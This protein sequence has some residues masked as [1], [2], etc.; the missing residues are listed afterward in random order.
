MSTEVWSTGP[1][2]SVAALAPA[3]GFLEGCVYSVGG[4]EGGE[5]LASVERLCE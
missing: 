1:D 4:Y 5:A 2:L 3:G